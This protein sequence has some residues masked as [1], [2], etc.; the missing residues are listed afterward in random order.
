MNVLSCKLTF[1]VLAYARR[2]GKI[3]LA[4]ASSGIAATL[5]LGGRTAHV[6]FKIPLDLKDDQPVCGVSKT[7]AMAQVIKAAT[8][9]LWDECTM[10]HRKCFEAVDRLLKDLEDNPVKKKEVMGGKLVKI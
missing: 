1:F 8:L 4:V 9:I 2:G 6:V 3:A 5:L 7:S 10:S